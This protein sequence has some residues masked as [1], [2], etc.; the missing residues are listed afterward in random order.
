MF[1]L[2]SI[3]HHTRTNLTNAKANTDTWEIDL[4]STQLH[5]WQVF[6]CREY[7]EISKNDERHVCK[8]NT[9][10]SEVRSYIFWTL[11]RIF[12]RYYRF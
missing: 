3:V 7:D 10:V 4:V 12:Q 6:H 9:R 1:Y 11:N 2:S 8:W 5:P